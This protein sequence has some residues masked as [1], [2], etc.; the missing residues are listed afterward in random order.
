MG[1][2]NIFDQFDFLLSAITD[3]EMTLT[4]EKF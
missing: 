3:A 2:L 1:I 4:M